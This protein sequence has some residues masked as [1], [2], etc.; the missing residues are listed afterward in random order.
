MKRNLIS[1]KVSDATAMSEMER[2]IEALLRQRHRIAQHRFRSNVHGTGHGRRW[3]KVICRTGHTQEKRRGGFDAI[4]TTFPIDT[5]LKSEVNTG[6]GRQ[7][8]LHDPKLLGGGP[9][10]SPLRTG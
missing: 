10:R 4:A 3:R 7:T 9:S 6:R 5:M 1:I 8:L 2:E